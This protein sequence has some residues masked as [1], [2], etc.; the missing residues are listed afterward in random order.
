MGQFDLPQG[1]IGTA[2]SGEKGDL[3]FQPKTE[4]TALLT[5]GD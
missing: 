5:I 3:R 4:I 1:C 2:L